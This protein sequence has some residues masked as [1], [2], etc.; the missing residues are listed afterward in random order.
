MFADSATIKIT[1]FDM[2]M[3]LCSQVGTSLNIDD[4]ILLIAGSTLTLCKYS[5]NQHPEI[6]RILPDLLNYLV[7][8][9]SKSR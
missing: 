2:V 3:N 9:G 1:K 6:D 5:F 7:P 4:R 8:G